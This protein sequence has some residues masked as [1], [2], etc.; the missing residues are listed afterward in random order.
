MKPDYQAMTHEELEKVFTD[1]KAMVQRPGRRP[2]PKE[3]MAMILEMMDL[4][5]P[6]L[7]P[8]P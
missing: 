8:L 4:G 3:D 5:M 7:G 1:R 2:L 6:P